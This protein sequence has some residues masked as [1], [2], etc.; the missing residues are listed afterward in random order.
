MTDELLE[1]ERGFWNAAG[2]GDYYGEHM[3]ANGL[4]VLPVGVLDKASTV[5]AISSADPWDDF[6]FSD[7]RIVDLGDDEAALCYRA[8]ASRAGDKYVALIST[9]YTRLS[10]EWK[11]TLHQQTPIET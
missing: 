7:V 2:D 8:E 10:G 3:A 1:L 5:E 9:V 6:E 11:L 4:C